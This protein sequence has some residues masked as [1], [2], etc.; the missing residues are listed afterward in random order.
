MKSAK[1]LSLFLVLVL[2]VS[3]GVFAQS[4]II[5]RQKMTCSQALLRGG[6]NITYNVGDVWLYQYDDSSFQ[7]AIHYLDGSQTEYIYLKNGYRQSSGSMIY[8]AS[9]STSEQRHIF[10]LRAEITGSGNVMT[11]YIYQDSA[12]VFALTLK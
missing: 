11:I 12:L 2:V 10:N 1:R 8:D 4:R 9:M 5:D 7:V 6:R 3:A